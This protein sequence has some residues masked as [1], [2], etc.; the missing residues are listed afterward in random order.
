LK[1]GGVRAIFASILILL[2]LPFTDISN[3]RGNTYRPL[4]RFIFWLFVAN[5][6]ILMFVG[7]Q[8]VEAPYT[9]I[10]VY[11]TIFYFGYFLILIPVIG[12]IEN[13]IYDIYY[14]VFYILYSYSHPFR[15]FYLYYLNKD[16]IYYV[17]SNR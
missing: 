14:L 15:A 3:I 12:V 11:S 7:S 10:G 5:F 8:H 6:F 13:T 1:I 4:H 16:Y 9:S 17:A 2:V